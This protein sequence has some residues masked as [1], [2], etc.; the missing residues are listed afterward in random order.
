MITPTWAKET[1]L[2]AMALLK[3]NYRPKIVWRNA[4]RKHSGGRAYLPLGKRY[5]Y[6]GK[7]YFRYKGRQSKIV[8]T[9]GTDLQD[10]KL[11]LLHEI[12]HIAN[13]LGEVHG[14][15]FW[16]TAWKL[17]KHFGIDL[18]YTLNRE[19]NYKKEAGK[20]FIYLREQGKL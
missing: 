9:A 6:K 2:E 17:Y 15:N 13:P 11:V 12:A 14:K 4:D 18:D 8:V 1:M 5:V 10:Q 16:R 19:N 3:C 7:T 20:Q